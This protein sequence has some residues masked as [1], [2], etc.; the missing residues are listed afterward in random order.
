MDLPCDDESAGLSE[1]TDTVV[2]GHLWLS[3]P[4]HADQLVHGALPPPASTSSA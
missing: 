4:E 3:Q 2:L 1:Y